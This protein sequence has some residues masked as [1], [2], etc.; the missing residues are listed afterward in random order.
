[1]I[2]SAIF[3]YLRCLIGFCLAFAPTLAQNAQRYV[4]QGK[5]DPVKITYQQHGVLKLQSRTAQA[6]VNVK[7]Y[8]YGCLRLYDGSDPKARPETT[9]AISIRVLDEVVKGDKFFLLL[10]I[11][12]GS[13]CNVQ[14]RCGAGEE[15]GVYWWQF[16]S[17]LKQENFQHALITSCQQDIELEEWDSKRKD[18]Y[19]VKLETRNGKLALKYTKRDYAQDNKDKSYSL[20]YDRA[21]PEHG[22][23]I[24]EN[25]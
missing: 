9:D 14:G 11:S 5:N 2:K 24:R 15:M 17:A 8:L 1:M 6:T 12:T 22:L 4:T 19:P 3:L 18:E 16:N 23:L 25:K 13:G 20:T 21:A 10:Q 7:K